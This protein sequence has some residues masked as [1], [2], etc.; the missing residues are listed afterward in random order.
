M[1]G[2]T[3]VGE[4]FTSFTYYLN[5]FKQGPQESIREYVEREAKIWEQVQ[6][7]VAQM[8]DTEDVEDQQP[9]HDHL[10]GMLLL[11]R[12]SIQSRDYPLI[13]KGNSGGTPYAEI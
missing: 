1:S 4:L 9:I 2:I 5:T 7:S 12:S 3:P 10:R 6:E 11:R 13:F 8:D